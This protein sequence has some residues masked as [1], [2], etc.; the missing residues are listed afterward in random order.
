MLLIAPASVGHMITIL[1]NILEQTMLQVV[2]S[3]AL[4]QR[5]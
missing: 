1:A 2:E 3:S 5:R 4:M